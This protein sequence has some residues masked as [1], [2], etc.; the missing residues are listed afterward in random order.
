MRQQTGY[1][2]TLD[3]W[4]AI[5]VLMVVFYHDSLHSV[6]PFSS[7]WLQ[8][9][10]VL[11]VDIF[12]GISGLLICSRLL[13]E[14]KATNAIS[15]SKFYI[16][17]AFRILPP[18]VLYL[19]V[20]AV[21]GLLSILPVLPK[22]W[23]AALFFFRNYSRF[24]STP[25]H[26]DWFTAHFWSLS[27]E[28]HFYF[29]LPSILVFVPK[30][31]RLPT[32][33]AIVTV[34]AGWRIYRQQTRPLEFLWHHTDT[35]LDAL[36]V[37]AMLAIV[38]AHPE[39]RAL[40]KRIC[41]F[42][43]VPAGILVYLLT[44]DRFPVLAPLLESFLI[45]MTLLGTVLYPRGFFARI[46]EFPPIRWLGKIS[47]SLYL[48][49]EMFFLQRFLPGYRP[50]GWTETFPAQWAMLLVG[51]TLSY[52][53]VEKPMVKLGHRLAP[54]ATPGRPETGTDHAELA[55]QASR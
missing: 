43:F 39:G 52:Y 7:R 1:M 22:E 36:L 49:Q 45:P 3:G 51:A 28:E 42:W 34:V 31:W 48:W 9:H 38:L 50:L 40:L 30:S 16:R 5:A 29:L 6:G 21:L 53:L 15:L 20:V 18:A 10:G 13:E 37:P 8:E 33:G 32:L 19:G 24:S 17:R 47:Y 4:R 27:L 11:G 23:F 14:E 55:P 54:P 41:R 26:L 35:R 46:L 44:S 12:F 2:P 25:G